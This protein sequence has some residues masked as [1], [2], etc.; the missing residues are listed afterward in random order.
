M[1]KLIGSFLILISIFSCSKETVDVEGSS[2]PLHTFKGIKAGSLRCNITVEYGDKQQVVIDADQDVLD[3]ISY[4]ISDDED[5]VWEIKLAENIANDFYNNPLEISIKSPDFQSCDI[6]GDVKVKLIDLM[7]STDELE[8]DVEG[9]SSLDASHM[10]RFTDEIDISV[11]NSG[12]VLFDE[13]TVV[14]N[15]DL[16]VSGAAVV[17]L[18]GIVQEYYVDLTGSGNVNSEELMSAN[19]D[20]EASGGSSI[21]VNCSNV[22]DATA[23]GSGVIEYVQNNTVTVNKNVSGGAAVRPIN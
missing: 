20:V 12:N 8:I 5:A 7:S 21:K 10:G 4:E 18:R 19:A 3:A 13:Y 14:K 22:L 23:S 1:K 2:I 6:S 16:D 15:I 17:E 11:K 9:N